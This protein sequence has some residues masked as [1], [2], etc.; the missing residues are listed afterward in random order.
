MRFVG[1][2]AALLFA[3]LATNAL[4]GGIS[5]DTCPDVHGESTNTCPSGTVGVP[6]SIRFVE[7]EGA[8][9]GPGRQTFHFDSGVL[10]PGFALTPDGTLSGVSFVA[11]TYRFYI[12]MREPLDDPANCAGKRTQKQFTLA[13]R[14]Q[15]WVV[16]K[17]IPEAEVGAP[18]ELALH[19]R[20]GSGTFSWRLTKG[21]LPSGVRLG[22]DGLIR[23]APHVSGTY[24]VTAE[25][26][27]TESRTVVWDASIVVSARLRIRTS[28][29]LRARLG[30]RYGTGLTT[31]G[32]TGSVTWRLE[33]GRLPRGLRQ[34]VGHLRRDPRRD[35]RA[36]RRA[37]EDVRVARAWRYASP[38][39]AGAPFLKS[40][41]AG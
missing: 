11:G 33:H 21:R 38:D 4:G 17:R 25:A 19:A 31:R 26:S 8:G 40:M 23:G 32:G 27:D 18:F 12:E 29:V 2:C 5:D 14:P 22:K 34:G 7:S 9:C 24:G 36:R 3:L 6:Y 15:P 1:L 20:G 30:H 13:I 28:H 39:P 10:P 35:R 16:A 41:Y 37:E